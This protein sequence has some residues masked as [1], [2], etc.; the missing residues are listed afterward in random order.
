MKLGLVPTHTST[1]FLVTVNRL[2]IELISEPEIYVKIV[3]H[4]ENQDH[5]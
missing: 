4:L 1:F 3:V 2:I 5:S